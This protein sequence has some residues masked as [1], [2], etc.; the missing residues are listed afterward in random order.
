MQ[1]KTF[2]YTVDCWL[3]EKSS[4]FTFEY[5]WNIEVFNFDQLSRHTSKVRLKSNVRTYRIFQTFFFRIIYDRTS[6]DMIYVGGDKG[7]FVRWYLVRETVIRFEFFYFI[8][9]LLSSDC[10]R[11]DMIYNLV[12][13]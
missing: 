7:L 2:L 13:D 5:Q 12:I 3:F 11:M 6:R 1:T 10:N 4:V 8:H 9:S